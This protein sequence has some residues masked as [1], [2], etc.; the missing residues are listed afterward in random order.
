MQEQSE[1]R[2]LW[3]CLL[4]TVLFRCLHVSSVRGEFLWMGTV[5]LPEQQLLLSSQLIPLSDRFCFRITTAAIP[6]LQSTNPPIILYPAGKDQDKMVV[7]ITSLCQSSCILMVMEESSLSSIVLSSGMRA[8]VQ[9][10][11]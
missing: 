2:V 8:S 10:I 1:E 7:T 9:E 6:I 5:V 11:H 4:P 3:G